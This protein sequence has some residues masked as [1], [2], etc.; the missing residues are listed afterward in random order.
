MASEIL[1]A[2]KQ[3][4]SNF[5]PLPPSSEALE[6]RV[7]SPEEERLIAELIPLANTIA[8]DPEIA[9]AFGIMKWEEMGDSDRSK[10]FSG[11]HPWPE[12]KINGQEYVYSVPVVAGILPLKDKWDGTVRYSAISVMKDDWRED[13]D[14]WRVVELN[15]QTG[16]TSRID[17]FGVTIDAKRRA[18]IV[19]KPDN[20]DN[21]PPLSRPGIGRVPMCDLERITA[22][23]DK[24]YH[25]WQAQYSDGLRQS[26]QIIDIE[27]LN[28]AMAREIGAR[29]DEEVFGDYDELAVPSAIT[30]ARYIIGATVSKP[31]LVIA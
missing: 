25:A 5:N 2:V 16:E 11:R 9:S 26:G 17:V 14:A 28:E 22:R 7:Y 30:A 3:P 4:Y 29:I 18:N 10:R 6:H 21:I 27:F 19:L 13:P 31:E 23:L 24:D 1:A 8:T 12:R 20:Y 15:L